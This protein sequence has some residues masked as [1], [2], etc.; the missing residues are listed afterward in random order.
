LI[1]VAS[2]AYP[3]TREESG[4]DKFIARANIAHLRDKL[5]AEQDKTPNVAQPAYRA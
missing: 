5:A 3:F 1:I 2:P 4:M